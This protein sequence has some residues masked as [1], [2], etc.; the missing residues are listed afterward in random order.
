MQNNGSIWLSH[1]VYRKTLLL[2]LPLT[3]KCH[4]FLKCSLEAG[5]IHR[6]QMLELQKKE[7]HLAMVRL[8]YLICPRRFKS[9]K[10]M[11]SPMA[12]SPPQH[13]GSDI[14]SIYGTN[15]ITSGL[16]YDTANPKPGLIE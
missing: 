11:F 10:D 9:F 4:C 1:F 16:K 7:F 3:D 12:I 8:V 15:V 5:R 6:H 2:L 13:Y 14:S